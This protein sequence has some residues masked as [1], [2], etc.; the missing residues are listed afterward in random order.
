[1]ATYTAN[2][3]LH[4]WVPEDVFVRTDFN[5]DLSKIDTGLKQ[6]QA[7][8]DSKCSIVTG[9]YTGDGNT[10]RTIEL[11]FKPKA[12]Y[13]DNEA[14]MRSGFDLYGG[15]LT[16]S[17]MLRNDYGATVQMTQTGFQLHGVYG[18][19]DRMSLNQN[20]NNYVYMAF[21]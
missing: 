14:G 12:L 17:T 20:Y 16:S 18:S 13:I 1:M 5:T 15:L 6:A 21:R 8:A 7:T 11:G 9:C 4:Q 3:G 2:Y 10:D 19:P